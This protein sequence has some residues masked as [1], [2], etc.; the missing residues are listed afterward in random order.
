MTAE[1]STP[2]YWDDDHPDIRLLT[3]ATDAGVPA[4]LIAEKI[5]ARTLA[6]GIRPFSNRDCDR[7]EQLIDVR[8]ARNELLDQ[9]EWLATCIGH[10][11]AAKR[12][13]ADRKMS[14]A[15]LQKLIR[16]THAYARANGYDVRTE[17][18]KA[19][20]PATADQVDLILTLLRERARSGEGGGFYSGATDRA[21]IARMTRDQASSYI[22][23]LRGDY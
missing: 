8:T 1:N 11:G 13:A 17:A 18:E 10:D 21:G 9:V 22:N 6:S 15:E 19:P 12:R 23:S 14:D 20:L 5:G 3:K 2:T 7:I 4:A 16:D